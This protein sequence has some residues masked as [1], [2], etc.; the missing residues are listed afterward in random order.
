MN[1]VED[2]VNAFL[3]VAATDRTNGE[4]YNLGGVE[5][6]SLRA[7]VETLIQV[8]GR[9]SYR[10]VPFPEEGKR[11]DI[12]DY[13]GC[14]EKISA[15]VGWEPR[16]ALRDGLKATLEYYAGNLSYYVDGTEAS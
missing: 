1:Y 5:T 14:Y 10:I 13:W 11:I 4:V 7:F 12:G 3:L 2:V 8:A 6:V 9:G 15:A 16:V